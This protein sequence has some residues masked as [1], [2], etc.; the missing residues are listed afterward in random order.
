MRHLT[1]EQELA[2][3]KLPA[4]V[5]DGRVDGFGATGGEHHLSGSRSDEGGHLLACLFDRDTGDASVGVHAARIGVVVAQER[6]HRV[7][8][9]WTQ[10]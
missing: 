3:A 7:E 6:D 8:R 10:R 4:T 9:A 1:D 2:N 5:V